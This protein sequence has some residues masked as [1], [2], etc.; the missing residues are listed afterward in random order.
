MPDTTTTDA[1]LDL[2]PYAQAS[3]PEAPAATTATSPMAESAVPTT[4]SP[5]MQSALAMGGQMTLL[6]ANRGIT[7][8]AFAQA[9]NVPIDTVYSAMTGRISNMT[10][11]RLSLLMGKLGAQLVLQMYV[12]KMATNTP[13]PG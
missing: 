7:P 12:P 1:P 10:I 5:S 8:E 4:N 9:T 11:G 2:A 3:Q 6:M 13:T